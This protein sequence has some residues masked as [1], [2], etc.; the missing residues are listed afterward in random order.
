MWGWTVWRGHY[1]HNDGYFCWSRR[2]EMLWWG[3]GGDGDLLLR[4]LLGG[5]GGR[6]CGQWAFVA[7]MGIAVF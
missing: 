6:C 4:T 2:G 3:G 1:L 5:G 7:G